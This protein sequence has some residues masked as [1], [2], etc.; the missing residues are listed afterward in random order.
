[1]AVAAIGWGLWTAHRAE[2]NDAPD[3]KVLGDFPLSA[4]NPQTTEE[5]I[6]RRFRDLNGKPIALDG[7]I[8]APN[9][10]SDKIG[11]FQF[12]Y[13]VTSSGL[14]GPPQVQ[15]RVFVTVSGG[16]PIDNPGMY[17]TVTIHGILH[18]GIHRDNAGRIDSVYRMDV[19]RVIPVR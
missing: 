1:M 13:N 12:V 6:P 14:R 2:A 5:A 3:L 16:R 4:D 18:V 15:E 11:S 8:Y 19:D 7:F 17:T 10:A 9:A